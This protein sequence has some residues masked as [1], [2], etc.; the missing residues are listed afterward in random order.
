MV[1]KTDNIKNLPDLK[2]LA[3]CAQTGT[4][5]EQNLSEQMRRAQ[6]PYQAV[7][8][9]DVN[10][11]FAAYESGRCKAV[12]ADRSALVTRRTRLAQPDDHIVLDVSLSKEP[13]APAVLDGDSRWADT[14]RWI[15][16]ATIEAEELGI[17]SQNLAQQQNSGGAVVRRFLGMDGSLGK[18]MGIANDFAARVVRHVGNYSEIYDRNLG[19]G[20]VFRLPR[21]QNRLWRDGGLMYA[22]PFR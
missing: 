15:I 10:A 18:D 13:L 2:D 20:S 17:S 12:T 9:E 6:I 21:A 1:R 3:I 11:T 5:T 7:V 16:Y 22:P 8:F 19:E 14:V 4:T